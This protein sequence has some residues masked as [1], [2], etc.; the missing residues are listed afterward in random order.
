M[1][2]GHHKRLQRGQSVDAPLPERGQD[3]LRVF[4]EAIA[5]FTEVD[6]MDTEAYERAWHRV[7]VAARRYVLAEK[8]PARFLNVPR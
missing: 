4:R 5:H 8:D 3:P 7:R 2:W 6:P 1:C